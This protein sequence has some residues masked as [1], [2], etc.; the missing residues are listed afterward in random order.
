LRIESG[1]LNGAPFFFGRL[2]WRPIA[3]DPAIKTTLP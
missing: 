2:I 3:D 1:A